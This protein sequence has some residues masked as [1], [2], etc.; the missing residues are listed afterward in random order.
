MS[1]KIVSQNGKKRTIQ[2][3]FEIGGSMFETE[4]KFQAVLNEVGLLSMGEIL[5]QFDTDG[6]PI[7]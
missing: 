2:F 3:E 1:P 7:I 4:K 5:A 6:E